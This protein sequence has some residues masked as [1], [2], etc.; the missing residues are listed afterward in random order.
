MYH[1]K[2]NM[3]NKKN[4][5]ITLTSVVNEFLVAWTR[6]YPNSTFLTKLHS[7]ACV[8]HKYITLLLQWIKY[9]FYFKRIEV[10]L[11]NYLRREL[12]QVKPSHSNNSMNRCT[13]IGIIISINS[14]CI[15]SRHCFTFLLIYCTSP[16]I[17]VYMSK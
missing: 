11:I 8:Y 5:F 7:S 12:V 2:K 9:D 6:T 16:L 10:E 4:M 13:I 15:F 1:K 3:C 17:I 14:T